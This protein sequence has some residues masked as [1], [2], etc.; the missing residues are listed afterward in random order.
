MS[1]EELVKTQFGSNAEKYVN[2]Q[3]HA[4]GSDLQ[5]VVQQVKNRKNIRL[6]D[7]A[8]GGGHVANLLAPIFKEVVALDLTEKMLEKAKAF[9]QTNGHE[10]VSFVVGNAEDL[11]FSNQSFDTIICRIA[12]HH[13]SNPSQ[14]IFEVHRKLEENGLFILIDNV[15]PENLE[16]DTF[17]NFIEKKRD[18]SHR[19][20][21]RKTEWISLLEKQGLQMQSC[22]TFEKQFNFDWWCNMMDVPSPT[23]SK[24]TDCMMKASNEMKEFFNIQFNNN[25]V[26]SFYTEMALFVCHK[27]STL[28][29]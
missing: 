16:Y 21:L 13:F 27:S 26:E 10:N 8:T 4:K 12:A 18:P 23:R 20:A 19:R 7:I 6:L 1:N 5:Y 24:L 14:F 9:I 29:R 25:K 11:P 2:S 15:S 17:Y 28:K 22:F 3:I